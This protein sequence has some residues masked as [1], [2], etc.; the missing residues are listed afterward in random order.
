MGYSHKVELK[1]PSRNR[2]LIFEIQVII[3]WIVSSIPWGLY[4]LLV[5]CLSGFLGLMLR[6]PSALLYFSRLAYKLSKNIFEGDRDHNL[7]SPFF[8]SA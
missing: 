6:K 1:L 7:F 8:H 4:S 5:A 3:G 2:I